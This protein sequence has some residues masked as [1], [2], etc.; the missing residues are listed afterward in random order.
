MAKKFE[1]EINEIKRENG[2]LNQE[3]FQKIKR[4]QSEVDKNRVE[5]E[6]LLLKIANLQ[7]ENNQLSYAVGEYKEKQMQLESDYFQSRDKYEALLNESKEDSQ[8]TNFDNKQRIKESLSDVK[9]EVEA[10]ERFQR[11]FEEAEKKFITL[12]KESEERIQDLETQVMAYKPKLNRASEEKVKAVE[13]LNKIEAKQLQRD[14]DFQRVTEENKYLSGQVAKLSETNKGIIEKF[15]TQIEE[16]NIKLAAHT[17]GAK[18]GYLDDSY[19]Q[20]AMAN[21]NIHLGE[22]LF[23]MEEDN[24]FSDVEE[25]LKP[26]DLNYT[27]SDTN[28]PK[29][30]K[31]GLVANQ[32]FDSVCLNAIQEQKNGLKMLPDDLENKNGQKS[33]ISMMETAH[34]ESLKEYEGYIDAY[35][36]KYEEEHKVSSK[37]QMLSDKYKIALKMKEDEIESFRQELFHLKMEQASEMNSILDRFQKQK[38][39]IR[40]LKAELGIDQ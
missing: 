18:P 30:K 27:T 20:G 10:R 28:T 1:K 32:S 5:K 8:K 37:Y 11:L 13:K 3:H 33:E 36:D 2:I 22:S 12:K 21:Q 9:Q 15:E 19:D 16:L 34:K 26:L 23:F 38:V 6:E 4:L 25:E 7:Q 17:N 29:G 24:Q 40:Q 31:V 35:K 14:T 39:L